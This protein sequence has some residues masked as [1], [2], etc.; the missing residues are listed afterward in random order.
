MTSL[1]FILLA[2][3]Q[4]VPAPPPRPIPELRDRSE[5]YYHF[6]LG[7]QARFSGETQTSLEEYRKAQKLDP[8]SA[9]IRVETARLLR[10]AGKV[11][12]A[13][14]EARE[15]VRLDK[16]NAEA[17]LALAQLYE[18]HAAGSGG[19]GALRKSAAELEEVI[20]LQPTDRDS[21][22]S[23]ARIYGQQLQDHK[24]AARIWQLYVG[25]DPGSFEAHIQAGTHLL[26][27]GQPEKAAAALKDALEL[28]PGSVRV[29][30]ILG[31]IYAQAEQT[32]QAVLHYRKA[33]EIEP[34][35]VRVRLGLTET[36]Y[37]ARRYKESLAEAQ[38]V[39]GSDARNR[40]ALNLKGQ[41]LRDL[42]DFDAAEEAANAILSEASSGY[43]QD[44]TERQAAYLQGAYLKVQIA[45]GRRDFASAASQ[46]ESILARNRSGEDVADAASRDRVFLIHLGFAYQQQGKFTDAAGAFGRAKRVGGDPD[47]ALLGYHAEALYLAKQ[48]DQA[49][50][51]VR[52]ARSRFPDDPDLTGLEATILRE[53]GDMKAATALVEK[54]RKGSPRDVKV[55]GQVADFY[56]RAKKF[57]EAEAA[58]REAREVEPKNLGT[59]FQL[60][61]VLE[62]Q[63][64]H[65]DADLVFREA[66][67]LEPNSAPVLNYV[68]YMNADRNVKVEEALE[69][70]Q[71]ALALE[72][73]NSAYLDS[74][75]W[76]LFRLGRLDAAEASVR[77]ALD[78]QDKNAVI[79]DHLGDIL[80]GRGRTAEALESWQKALRGE[81]D[82]GELDRA[83][84]ER[85]IRDAQSGLRAQQQAP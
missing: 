50:S 46:L 70:I 24:E 38:T 8:G 32:D 7:L 30:Q 59:L 75:G 14:A 9:A 2:A 12:E 41:A 64:R 56:R 80:Q 54:L 49:L 63:Q 33:L 85:K 27:A 71:R 52:G 21:L 3:S 77:K 10:E 5:A 65:D 26:A 82:E 11:D 35:N 23:L 19:E 74:M 62:R 31:D 58:L 78:R 6:S 36:L 68:G 83:R 48:L 1:V 39:L 28:Q 15:A 40:F 69:M 37:R 42:R 22:V 29:Y 18:L 44:P 72:P 55:L 53:K 60:G 17:H 47:A 25:V 67:K 57:P 43:G 84:V 13:L 66:L 51:E 76:A 16:D 45:E 81:D 20:R 34:N 4:S 73:N 79:L 61:A